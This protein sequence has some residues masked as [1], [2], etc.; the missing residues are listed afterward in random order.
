MKL[1]IQVPCFN[2]EKTLPYVMAGIPSSIEGID[3]IYTLIINDGSKDDTLKVAED[4]GVDYI[5]NNHC[6]MGLAKSFSKGLDAC[7][8]LGAD[9]I[10]NLDG[11]NQYNAADI[12]K[13]VQPI[14]AQKADIVVGCRDIKNHREFSMLKKKLQ[15][16]GSKVV[17]RLSKTGV[18]DTTSGFRA[19]GRSA[20]I[21]CSVMSSFSYTLEM[22][23]QS[24]KLGLKISWRPIR[25]NAKTRESRLF[26][27]I[28][29]FIMSQFKTVSKVYLFYYPIKFFTNVSLFFLGLSFLLGTRV[30]YFLWIADADALKFKTGTGALLIFSSIVSIFSIFTG[31]LVSVLSGLRFLMLDMRIRIRN[32]ELQQDFIP[33][34]LDILTPSDFSEGSIH[35]SIKAPSKAQE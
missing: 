3:E 5:V 7:L 1:F 32:I 34:G 35:S 9:V 21:K 26:K 19:L 6:N 2:E 16:F 30:C 22:L 4:L 28:P 29:H 27:S 24:R 23:I 14:L 13:L 15:D 33:V 18:P 8:F 12:G 17:K 10:V 20:A 11:D 25:V 31:L